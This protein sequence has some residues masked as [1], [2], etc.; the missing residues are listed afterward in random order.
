VDA[1]E[2]GGGA[3]D[4]GLIAET[5]VS[6]FDSW[7]SNYWLVLVVKAGLILVFYLTAFLIVSNMEHK[8]LAHMQA[9][10]GPM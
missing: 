7:S 10:I 3:M 1:A 4:T 5:G 9:R 6:V 8:V 2:P